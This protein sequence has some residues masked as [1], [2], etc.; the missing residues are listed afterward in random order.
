[1]NFRNRRFLASLPAVLAATA[2]LT[3]CQVDTSQQPT[4]SAGEDFISDNPRGQNGGPGQPGDGEGDAGSGTGA[5]SGGGNPPPSAPGGNDDAERAITEADIIQ[6]HEGKLYALSQYSGLSIIDIS[7]P[8]QLTL[9]GRHAGTSGTPFEMYLRD[10]VV[11]AM[12]SS[13]GEY[14]WDAG[15]NSYSYVQSS[16]I[17]ALDVTNPGNIN[18]IGSFDLPGSISDSRVVGDVLYAVTFEDGYCWNCAP[19]PNTTITS[20]AIASPEDIS[21]VDSLSFADNDPYGYGWRRSV[22]ATADRMYVSGIEWDGSSD[23][24]ST[25]QVVDISDPG[26]QLELGAVVEAEGQITSR[27][28]MDEH[29]GVL[30]VVSQPGIWWSDAMP[31]VQTFSVVSSQEVLPLGYTQLTL[32]MPET[33]RSVRFDGTRAYAITAQQT[34]PLF[35]IDL[36]NPAQPAQVGELEMPGWIYHMEPRGDRLLALGFDN[37]DPEGSL[38]VSLFDVSNLAQPTMISR[39][40]FGGQWS[41]VAEDQDRIHKAFRIL[42]E[43]GLILVPF[44]GWTY[45]EQGGCGSYESG[46]QLLDFSPSS[47][48]KRGVAQQRGMARRAFLHENRLFAVSDEEVRTFSITNRDAPEKAADLGLATMAQQSIIAGDLVVRLAAD[49]WTTAARLEVVPAANPSQAEPIGAVELSSLF[50]SAQG[51]YGWGLYGARL[52][53]N[54][55]TVYLVWPSDDGNHVRVATVDLSDAQ[56][57][58]IAGQIELPFSAYDLYGYYGAPVV[59][60]GEPVAQVGSTLVFRRL[61][62][63]DYGYYDPYYPEDGNGPD[64]A[65][66]LRKAW[67]EVVD[68]S[69]PAQPVHAATVDLPEASGHTLMRVS[70]SQVLLSHWVPLPNDS[71]KARFYFDRVD[72]SDPASPAALPPVNVPGSLVTF[73]SSVNRLLTVDYQRLTLQNVTYEECYT[74]YSYEA[75]FEPNDPYNYEGPGTCTAMKRAFKLVQ[76]QGNGAHL[77]ES[78][79]LENGTS[80]WNV[81]VGDDRVFAPSSNYGWYEDGGGYWSSSRILVLGGIHDGALEI[82][83]VEGAELGYTYPVA[84]A[85]TRLVS[86][87]YSP[88][89]IWTLD[90]ADMDAMAFEQKAE[91]RSYVSHVNVSGDLALCSLG[92]YGLEVVNLAE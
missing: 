25:I 14:L 92:A 89:G 32:P 59:T 86:S 62:Q 60:S 77:I 9:L 78:Y 85:G 43:Q 57:P 23:G 49:W 80:L 4:P 88:S 16:H 30:R 58:S 31:A 47:L 70:G 1:M 42:D 79:P 73:D 24:H 71:T 90:A 76:V 3:G 26:G 34:D 6:V 52:F 8:D 36:S 29:E 19:S 20:L 10:G 91:L 15:T 56:N 45:D 48:V 81:F 11:Y 68:L 53:A 83:E 84:V 63:S 18:V 33:L 55:Q 74:E 22:S 72:V 44:A 7:T 12:F 28:Q 82:A 69:N 54:G 39:E 50:P 2:A 46:I 35:T 38:N 64:P 75:M 41:N 21:V 17:E 40:G 51:C 87:G 65:A 61:E 27:W 5:G 37:T 13:W 67:L 66:V